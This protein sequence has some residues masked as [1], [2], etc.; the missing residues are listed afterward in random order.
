[1]DFVIW[2]SQNIRL[3]VYRDP[4]T[5][6][7][8]SVEE[9]ESEFRARLDQKRR[10][11]RDELVEKLRQKYAPKISA[12]QEKINR[13]QKAVGI[14]AEQAKQQKVQTAVSIGA[15]L[16]G[17]FMGRKRI[18]TSSYGRGGSA[19]KGI[20][21]TMKETKDVQNAKETLGYQSQELDKINSEFD[22][23]VSMLDSKTKKESEVE[24]VTIRPDKS[25]ISVKLVSLAW[26]PITRN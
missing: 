24:T 13:S 26:V 14:Q 23:E 16:L 15:T 22:N 10:E 21:R 18:G 17:A 3:N 5:Q 19:M 6:L 7:F 1:K 4:F 25:R 12:L 8:S 20:S 9:S 11:L 2:L